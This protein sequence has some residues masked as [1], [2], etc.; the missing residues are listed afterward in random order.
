MLN[1]VLRVTLAASLLSCAAFA[2]DISGAWQFTL[3]TA[4]GKGSPSFEF[5]QDGEKLTGTYSGKFGKASLSGTV[6]GDQVEFTFD[7][8]NSAGKF[9]YTGTI[10][11]ANMK[12]DYE[13]EGSEKGTFTAAK[14]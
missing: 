4:K 11:G 9:H 8:P 5:K 7:A 10:A 1:R 2:A 12:G 14:K 3:E 6:K 13:L